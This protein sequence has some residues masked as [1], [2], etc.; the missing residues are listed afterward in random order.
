MGTVS[1]KLTY[2]NTTKGKIKDVINITGANITDDTFR[3]Y[4]DKLKEAYVDIINNGTDELYSNFPKTTGEGVE[5]TLNNTFEAPMGIDLKGNTEQ[6]TYTG[7]NLL[8]YNNSNFTKSTT[9]WFFLDGVSGAYGTN[10]GDKT[11]IKTPVV[12]GETYTISC[13][14]GTDVLSFGAVYE[15]E[16]AIVNLGIT[17]GHKTKTFTADRDGYVIIRVRQTENLQ[18]KIDN[19]MI[20]K[21]STVTSYEP[22]VGGTPSPNP[23]YPQDVHVVSGD[24]TIKIEGKNYCNGINQN[25]YL[26]NASNQCGIASDNS[27]LYIEVNGGN[28]TISTTATQ[29]RY[30]VACSD[31]IPP[32]IGS[33]TA[34]NG[35]NKDGT[36]NSITIDTTGH[37][38]LIVNATDLTSIQI[39]KGSTATTYEPYQEQTYPL[40]LGSMEL[41]KIGNY[42]DLILESTGKNLFDKDNAN[43][44]NAYFSTQKTISSNANTKTLYITCKPNT[45]YTISKI[46]SERFRVLTTEVLPAIGTT[47]ID[48]SENETGTSIT[49]T[50][51]SNANYLCVFYYHSSYDTITEQQILNSIQIEENSSKTDYEPYGEVWYKKGYIGKVVLDGS[52]NYE[53]PNNVTYSLN[54]LTYFPNHNLPSGS[55]IFLSNY[56]TATNNNQ[57]IGNVYVGNSYMNFNYDGTASNI[58][59][60]KTWLSTHNTIVYYPLA[61]PTTEEITATTL[62]EQLEDLKTAKSVEGQTNITQVNEELP[63]I[64]DVSGLKKD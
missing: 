56:F 64:L 53:T 5:I 46:A 38:Y 50:T 10:I 35:Q 44:L 22:Y 14:L 6:T 15:D 25:V 48:Y 2:L 18:V 24:N 41:C 3:S 19:I 11:N 12:N 16:T 34:Y 39:E 23:D 60:F 42:Q 27:G 30:R 13:D 61:T 26:N 33:T 9:S 57:F 29:T 20:E 40:N 59:T 4:P 28:Y 31:V 1:D 49:I 51:S 47:G 37:K 45:T 36:S 8:T 43:T 7:K 52:E 55:T 54:K 58:N 21:S 17:S 62:I 63:F 32:S